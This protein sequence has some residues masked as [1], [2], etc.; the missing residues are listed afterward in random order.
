MQSIYVLLLSTLLSNLPPQNPENDL[1]QSLPN[2]SYQGKLY[3]GYLTAGKTKQFHY[4]FH[5]SEEDSDKKPLILWLNGGPGC[6]SLDGW[7]MENGPMFLN[8]DGTFR[9]NEYSWHKVGNMLYIESPGEVGFSY[10]DSKKEEDFQF[11][12]D[13]SAK[14][15]L[16]ALLSFFMK[17]PEYR[18]RDFYISGESYAGIYIPLLADEILKYNKD[19]PESNKINLKGIL[20]GNGVADWEYDGTYALLDYAFAHQLTSIELRLEYNEHCFKNYNQTKCTELTSKIY[21]LLDDINVYNYL[22]KCEKPTTET[23]EINFYSSYFLKNAWAFKNLK[24]MQ[25]LM[26][27]N[28]LKKTYIEKKK[29]SNEDEDEDEEKTLTVPCNNDKPM[30]D[31]F[32]SEEV[33]KAL[34]VKEDKKWEL[35]SVLVY[36]KYI[37][38]RKAS[39]WAYKRLINS[40]IRILIFNGDTDAVVPFLANFSWIEFLELKILEDWKQWRAYEDNENVSGYIIKYDGLT[41]TTVRGAGHEVSRYKPK[42]AFYMLTKFINDEEF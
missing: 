4:M 20:V 15:N 31:Y 29:V 36:E 9:E 24:T 2:Y 27:S 5:P 13:I 41:F 40:G 8:E 1:V 35:C 19:V 18:G 26:K 11:D 7:A 3:S 33:K 34:H 12:D 21:G 22:E 23:G 17:F 16:V 25:S 28:P 39:L 10:I 6:S 14:N 38:Q 37:M 42:E 30:R 32:N